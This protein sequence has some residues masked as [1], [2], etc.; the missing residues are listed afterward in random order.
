M[1]KPIIKASALAALLLMQLCLGDTLKAAPGQQVGGEIKLGGVVESDLFIDAPKEISGWMLNPSEPR[2]TKQI[3]LTIFAR[4]CW[5]LSV[6]SDR[7]NGRMAEFDQLNS[8][9]IKDGKELDSPL[10]I[11][12]PG[13]EDH[14]DPWD[15]DLTKG[16][17]IQEGEETAGESQ[18]LAV[19]IE[20]PVSWTDEPLSDGH[21]YHAI[22]V[23]TISVA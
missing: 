5:K 6:T 1:L 15:V 9:Y 10:K 23:F 21:C 20:Q 13:T 12:A 11:S 19:D 8:S 16:G 14:P 4:T 18:K 7:K 22:V 2:S 3:D 17:V